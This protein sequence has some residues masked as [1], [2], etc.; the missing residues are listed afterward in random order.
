MA[1]G[2]SSP[3]LLCTLVSLFITH[4]SLGLGTIVGS[5]I[6]NLLIICAG[7]VYASKV[8]DAPHE[9][10]GSRYLVL[11]KVMVIREVM[12]YGL[13][14]GMLYV[15]LSTSGMIVVQ[16]EEYGDYETERIIVS[17]W[18]ACLVFGLYVVYVIF[19]ANMSRIMS[20][21]CSVRNSFSFGKSDEADQPTE[22][23]IDVSNV[24]T[25]SSVHYMVSAFSE[26]LL[27]IPCCG[28]DFSIVL[29]QSKEF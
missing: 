4:S 5:E 20:M 26:H 9:K 14:I 17:F 16:D 3:E 13:S 2:A 15:A 22:R 19:C 25:P 24:A 28:T 1:A 29:S 18:K 10:Y 27:F 21:L 8:H 23:E 6:F 11:D 7:S 12:F